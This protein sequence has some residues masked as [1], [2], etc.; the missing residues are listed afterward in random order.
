MQRRDQ[1]RVQ[2]RRARAPP[3]RYMP[4][5][6]DSDEDLSV[7]PL[8]KNEV[9][10][11]EEAYDAMLDI[12]RPEDRAYVLP[13]GEGETPRES[14]TDDNDDASFVSEVSTEDDDDDYD[15]SGGDDDDDDDDDDEYDDT[16]GGDTAGGGA[17]TD[18]SESAFYS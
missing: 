11:E 12:E 9:R 13:D 14:D 8:E 17:E 7:D 2:P 3:Q 10:W 18:D 15:T 1:P 4:A 16:S 6:N 5:E